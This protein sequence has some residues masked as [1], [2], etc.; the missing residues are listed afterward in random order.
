MTEYYS[1]NFTEDWKKECSI[2]GAK[3]CVRIESDMGTT[4][5]EMCG[6]HFFGEA[7]MVDPDKWN[8]ED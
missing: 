4:D 8:G 2:C 3:P 1:P 7:D 5:T 6:P